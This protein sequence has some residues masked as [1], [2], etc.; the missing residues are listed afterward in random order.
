ML[1]PKDF[2]KIG[3]FLVNK[4]TADVIQF[5]Y[6]NKKRSD[7]KRLMK[8]QQVRGR[9]EEEGDGDGG[10][11]GETKKRGMAEREMRRGDRER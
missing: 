9:D 1:F 11:G 10:E 5:Y 3:T 4:S 7:F 8:Q 2:R 6:L